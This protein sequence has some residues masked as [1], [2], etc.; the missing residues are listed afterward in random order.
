MG[1]SECHSALTE[2]EIGFYRYSKNHGSSFTVIFHTRLAA[3]LITPARRRLQRDIHEA[4]FDALVI[5]RCL[6]SCF[7]APRLSDARPL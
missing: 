7:V 2:L 6:E 4:P 5:N 1:K 3:A